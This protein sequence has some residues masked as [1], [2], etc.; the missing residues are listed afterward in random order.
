MDIRERIL[1]ED[2]D[3]VIRGG[4]VS[5]EELLEVVEDILKEEE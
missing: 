4:L 1:T 3:V 5:E 2:I